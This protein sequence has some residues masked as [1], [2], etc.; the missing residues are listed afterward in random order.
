L[1]SVPIYPS[2]YLYTF[3][4]RYLLLQMAELLSERLQPGA[5]GQTTRV[6]GYY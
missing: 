6:H 4:R 3:V 1:N 2:I 5:Y